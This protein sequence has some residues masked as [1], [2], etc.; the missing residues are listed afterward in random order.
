MI[1]LTP[2]AA[3]VERGDEIFAAIMASLES[4]EEKSI[5]ELALIAGVTRR[6]LATLQ[7]QIN[8]RLAGSRHPSR[9]HKTYRNH[10]CYWHLK[11][12]SH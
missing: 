4:G 3:Q 9:I 1:A 11:P 6:R 7:W 12:L 2:T 10:R 5:S 8:L